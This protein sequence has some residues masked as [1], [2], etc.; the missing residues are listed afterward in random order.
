MLGCDPGW[1]G[2]RFKFS[3]PERAASHD[4]ML[5][6]RERLQRVHDI[7]LMNHRH[8]QISLALQN[9]LVERLQ[10]A[11]TAGEVFKMTPVQMA[12][13]LDRASLVE[14]RSRGEAT[15]IIK[16]QGGGESGVALDLS[17]LSDAELDVFQSLVS[18][19]QPT[20]P[21]LPPPM[22]AGSALKALPPGGNGHGPNGS[23]E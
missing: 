16:H 7:D 6:E 8:T 18:K 23:G 19:A 4:A 21:A 22:D 17:K 11:A 3:W 12:T 13:L 1:T 2:W 5:Y 9:L 15:S 10:A 20:Q 14:R